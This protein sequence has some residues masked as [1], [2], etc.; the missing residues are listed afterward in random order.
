MIKGGGGGG[1]EIFLYWH[2]SKKR[3]V[4]LLPNRKTFDS[5]LSYRT[6]IN[7]LTRPDDAFV[8]KFILQAKQGLTIYV[9]KN[10][11]LLCT[12]Q[13]FPKIIDLI[14]TEKGHLFLSYTFAVVSHLIHPGPRRG[15]SFK[16][17]QA[18]RNFSRKSLQ[19]SLARWW[20]ANSTQLSNHF[21]QPISRRSCCFIYSGT[22]FVTFPPD[23][24]SPPRCLNTRHSSPLSLSPC[25]LKFYLA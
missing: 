18:T 9:K 2:R 13:L 17:P 23:Y 24:R 8:V 5:S 7:I 1:A 3:Y 25:R 22:R 21:S 20:S 10:I 15:G 12:K 14:K 16:N 6:K 19:E 4:L 11:H